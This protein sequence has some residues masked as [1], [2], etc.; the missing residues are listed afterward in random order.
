MN[1]I[2]WHRGILTKMMYRKLDS[3]IDTFPA[4]FSKHKILPELIKAFEFGSG[5]AK[6]LSA[7]VKVGDHVSDEEYTSIIIEPIVRMFASPD[8]AIRV[9]LLENMPKFINHMTNKMVTNQIYPNIVSDKPR[10]YT[11]FLMFIYLGYW[12]LGYHSRYS[13]TNH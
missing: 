12:I 1:S 2:N 10:F 7:I 13:R 5:G 3:V 11:F 9:S 6:A 4:E 8:R